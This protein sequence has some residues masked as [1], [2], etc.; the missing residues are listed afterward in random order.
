MSYVPQMPLA[1]YSA[2]PTTKSGATQDQYLA[3]LPTMDMA[4]LQVELGYILGSVRYT[5]LGHYSPNHFADLR[6]NAPLLDLQHTIK[7][8]DTTIADRNRQRPRPYQFLLPT[9]IPQSINI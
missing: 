2:A 5:Q 8:I 3:M 7:Q 9:G 1:G 6:V 4:E